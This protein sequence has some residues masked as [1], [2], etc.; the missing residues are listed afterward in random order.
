MA[1]EPRGDLRRQLRG[2]HRDEDLDAG[3]P[4]ALADGHS[5]HARKGHH[6]VG[7]IPLG[8]FDTRLHRPALAVLT[9]SGAQ[10][11]ARSRKRDEEPGHHD[12]R[13]TPA[14]LKRPSRPY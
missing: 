3:L 12:A 9:C 5:D 13:E 11:G 4:V 10:A 1:F 7:E 8:L 14:P 2:A 6:L